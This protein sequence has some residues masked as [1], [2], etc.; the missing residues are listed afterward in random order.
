MKV[1]RIQRSESTKTEAKKTETSE[2]ISFSHVMSTKRSDMEIERLNQLV[3]NIEDQGKILAESATIEDLKQYKNLVKE[4][5]EDVVK[6]GVKIEQSRGFNRGGR[7]RIYKVI[8]KVDEK[9]LELSD[10][11][12]KRQEKGLTILKIVGQIKGLLVDIYA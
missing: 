1:D 10:A 12:L 9:L 8:S 7:T 4:F 3:Q 2:S 6:N 11:V 5:M